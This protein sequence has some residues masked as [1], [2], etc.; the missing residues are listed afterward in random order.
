MTAITNFEKLQSSINTPS[1]STI[2]KLNTLHKVSEF[3]S[4][5]SCVATAFFIAVPQVSLLYPLTAA[6]AAV[7][8]QEINILSENTLQI[9]SNKT[10][11][12]FSTTDVK[13]L[14]KTVTKSTTTARV[15]FSKTAE[16]YLS[17]DSKQGVFC[18]F[19]S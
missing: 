1:D 17:S 13:T 9:L 14:V 15:F 12:D 3:A 10:T 11:R 18:L 6:T 16:K 2:Q 8:S 5:T 7:L 4:I 19:G